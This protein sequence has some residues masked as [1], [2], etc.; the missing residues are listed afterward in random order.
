MLLQQQQ[1]KRGYKR[2]RESDR[3]D[4]RYLE[5]TGEDLLKQYCKLET[6][7]SYRV[8]IFA[9]NIESSRDKQR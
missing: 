4:R 5:T 9:L 6:V 7:P 2:R 3:C 1:H 8:L